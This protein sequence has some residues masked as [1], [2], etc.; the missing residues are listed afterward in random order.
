MKRILNKY[1]LTVNCS[2]D[3]LD[4]IR[5]YINNVSTK[6]NLSSDKAQ[7][8][9]MAVDEA[10]TNVIKHAC[11]YDEKKSLTIQVKHKQDELIIEIIDR[12]D[13][14]FDPSEVEKVDLKEF[15]SRRKKGGLGIHLIKNLMDDVEYY[16]GNGN[17]NRVKMV[18]HI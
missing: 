5:S 6:V 9:E 18:K 12:G 10:C 13:A 14:E 17:Q 2:T 1:K 16:I 11:A 15:V 3:N 8:V 4:M 7:Q